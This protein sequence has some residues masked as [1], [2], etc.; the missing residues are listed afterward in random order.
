[1]FFLL[2]S[3]NAP[4]TSGYWATCGNIT[5]LYLSVYKGAMASSEYQDD[6]LQRVVSHL[7]IVKTMLNTWNNLA[8]S[9]LSSFL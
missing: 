3:G 6:M 1:M 8:I 2:S 9:N 7:A 4:P 5:Y